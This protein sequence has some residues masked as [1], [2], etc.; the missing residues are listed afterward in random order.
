MKC[1]RL[2]AG[3]HLVRYKPKYLKVKKKSFGAR[4]PPGANQ[5]SHLVNHVSV[6]EVL[7]Q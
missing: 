1:A 3:L 5:G 2:V 7:T 4:K 6:E